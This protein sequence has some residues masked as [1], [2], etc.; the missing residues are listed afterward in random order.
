MIRTTNKLLLFKYLL[1]SSVFL[2]PACTSK[3]LVKYSR[4]SP[5][6]ALLP[7]SHA[8][9]ADGRARFRE[10]F[11][12]VLESHGE[13]L[14][15]YRPCK[16]AMTRIGLEPEGTGRK[17]YLGPS[18]Q[19]LVA[20]LVPG[21]GWDCIA[22]WLDPEDSAVKHVRS[23]GYDVTTIK[24][25]SLSSSANN[26]RQIRDEAK[27]IPEEL[28]HLPLVLIG[29]SK[30]T[31]DILEAIVEYPEL[32][33]KVSSVVS[34]AGSV[35]GSPI[36]NGATQDQINLLRHFPGAECEEGDG[37]ALESLKPATRQAWLASN[38]LPDDLDYYSLVTFPEPG[39]ISNVLSVTYNKLSYVDS[40]NDGQLLFYDQLVPGSTLLGYLNGDHWAVVIPIARTHSF[41]GSTFANE[42]D[43][44]REALL[45]A[46]LRFIEEDR[47]DKSGQSTLSGD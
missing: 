26:A 41:I 9:I 5:P 15:D 21:V 16:E 18:K 47:E 22:D 2:I 8:G 46:V 42:N 44:P 10:I 23:L 36:A 4:D 34:I 40:R 29:Y 19:N 20:A 38:P 11:C 1:I 43:Y 3:P 13:N 39:R 7:I 45:E 31:P 17:V 35:G 24:V 12:A 32:R 14:P 33:E 37:G 28:Q 6:I 30:G 27:N 25:D